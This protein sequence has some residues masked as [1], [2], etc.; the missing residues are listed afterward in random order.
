MTRSELNVVH[1]FHGVYGEA[2]VSDDGT[3]SNEQ[4]EN[5]AL[6]KILLD[7]HGA[8]RYVVVRLTQGDASDDL[9]ERYKRTY[10]LY[11]WLLQFKPI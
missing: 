6:E 7:A 9:N 8:Q 3:A 10:P 11:R 4:H 1:V 5:T 2:N